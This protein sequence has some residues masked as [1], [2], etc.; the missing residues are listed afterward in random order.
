M[1]QA[2]KVAKCFRR[3]KVFFV[4]FPITVDL[5]C[6]MKNFNCESVKTLEGQRQTVQIRS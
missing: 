1:S 5:G 6:G 2:Q 4:K 3:E